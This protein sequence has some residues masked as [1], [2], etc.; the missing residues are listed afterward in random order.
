MARGVARDKVSL[1][2]PESDPDSDPI[3]VLA[4]RIGF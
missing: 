4:V 1:T 3:A 2:L